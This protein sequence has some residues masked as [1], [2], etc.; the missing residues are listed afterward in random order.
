MY[1]PKTMTTVLVGL[2]LGFAGCSKANDAA[3]APADD[4]DMTMEMPAVPPTSVETPDDSEVLAVVNGTE[5]TRG[6]VNQQINQ[7]MQRAQG[8]IPP[9][10]LAQMRMQMEDQILE[11][12]ITRTLLNDAADAENVEVTDEDIAEAV[13]TI[14]SQL[15]PG[16]TIET[17][18]A[19]EGI[20]DEEFQDQ[21]RQEVRIKK[22]VDAKAEQVAEVGD[23]EIR[24]FYDENPD[25]F[26]QPESVVASHILIQFDEDDTEETKAEKREKI[27]ELRAQLVDGASFEELAQEHSDC[28]SA[29]R[30]GNLGRFGR[31]QMVK[32]FEEA[33]FS[34]ETGSIGDVIETQFGYHVIRVE[35]HDEAT[36]V[37]FEEVKDQIGMFLSSQEKQTAVQEYIEN[38]RASADIEVP[39]ETD[40]VEN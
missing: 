9:E 35:E 37:D 12:L 25:Q 18:I 8:R 34:Q 19:A 3:S 16:Q 24:A 7:A 32:P 30:G 22:L 4:V 14:Q 11:G 29:A 28:P 13:E 17:A 27:N 5:I 6:E 40:N 10:R 39:G 20:T 2:A 23:E 36:T 1:D 31:G 21:L 33:A 26:E 15:P 38:L